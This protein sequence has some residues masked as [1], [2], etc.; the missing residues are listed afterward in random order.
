MLE[1]II[2]DSKLE[3]ICWSSDNSQANDVFVVAHEALLSLRAA[4]RDGQGDAVHTGPCWLAPSTHQQWALHFVQHRLG[5][6][7]WLWHFTFQVLSKYWK[8]P[9]ELAERL[10]SLRCLSHFIKIT[11]FSANPI[12]TS[13]DITNW[14]KWMESIKSPRI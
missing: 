6:Q 10:I 3:R 8:I 12:N 4:L 2:F 13:W 14:Q 9:G 11:Y 5:N 1:L 7:Q